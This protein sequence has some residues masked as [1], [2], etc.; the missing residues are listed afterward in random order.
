MENQNEDSFSHGLGIITA[1][2]G[3]F[4]GIG[5][6]NDDPDMNTFLG[7]IIGGVIGYV[8][9]RIAGELLTLAIKII[10]GIISIL[11]IIFRIYRLFSLIGE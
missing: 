1:I 3:G 8:G 2:V 11:F 10:I 9:G 4:I 6:A 7:F 5:V